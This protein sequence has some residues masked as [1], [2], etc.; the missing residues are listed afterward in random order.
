MPGEEGH[1][2]QEADACQEAGRRRNQIS[3]RS[4]ALLLS[5]SRGAVGPGAKVPGE[6]DGGRRPRAEAAG[7]F[8]LEFE[9][10]YRAEAKERIKEHGGTAPGKKSK[11]LSG[12]PGEVLTG[13]TVARMAREAP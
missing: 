2:R 3:R 10:I 12:I 13:T 7:S 11:H 5:R 6:D 9:P 8:V 4:P 1:I